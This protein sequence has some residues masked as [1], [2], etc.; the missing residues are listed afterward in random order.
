MK[1][2]LWTWGVPTLALAT[3]ALAAVNGLGG[4]QPVPPP[5]GGT[6]GDSKEDFPAILKKMSAAKPAIQKKQEELLKQRYDLGNRPANGVTMTRG[7]P[8]Q[9]GPRTKLP[10][11]TSWKGR[12]CRSRN[13]RSAE[14]PRHW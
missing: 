10:Q 4:Q 2:S 7:K 3:I 5:G 8:V 9:A 13:S 14:M 6:L 11:G 1:H 12:F